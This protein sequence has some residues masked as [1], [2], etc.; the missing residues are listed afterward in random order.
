[1][2]RR[3]SRKIQNIG[4][5]SGVSVR[6]CVEEPVVYTTTEIWLFSGRL[7][8]TQ[9]FSRVNSG[10]PSDCFKGQLNI[11]S[12]TQKLC[13]QTNHL[14]CILIFMIFF[15]RPEAR[16]QSLL[17]S[18]RWIFPTSLFHIS[19]LKYELNSIQSCVD[20]SICLGIY[21]TSQTSCTDKF[22]GE[23]GVLHFE[24]VFWRSFFS[25]FTSRNYFKNVFD[26]PFS[27]VTVSP[28]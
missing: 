8:Y 3:K 21:A 2:N 22:K 4:L 11:I 24:R 12:C 25:G 28:L 14:N 16:I 5:D 17:Q 13:C 20:S 27:V 26:G 7:V 23:W 15:S 9:T 10:V 1:M 19:R 6:S 18:A